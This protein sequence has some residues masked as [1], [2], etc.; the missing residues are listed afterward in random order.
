MIL[1]RAFECSSARPRLGIE[2]IRK[3]REQQGSSLEV[4]VSASAAAHDHVE[5]ML[6]EIHKHYTDRLSLATL[7]R[8]LGR[9]G[10][11]L[12]RLFREHVGV[13][14]HDY[15]TRLRIEHGA[16]QVSSGAKIEA[17]ALCIGY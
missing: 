17:V 1:P 2:V 14:V 7:A 4:S 16:S 8:T 15:V 6:E 5:R 12:G 10:A 11:Y 13:T 9:Q 3:V